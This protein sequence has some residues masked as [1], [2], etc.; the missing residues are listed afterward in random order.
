M[1]NKIRPSVILWNSLVF[2]T[3]IIAAVIN[4]GA[5]GCIVAI[6]SFGAIAVLLEEGL[7]L[8]IKNK[9]FVHYWVILTPLVW[10][11]VLIGGILYAGVWTKEH[12]FDAISDKIDNKFSK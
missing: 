2:L 3:V 8:N 10:I 4:L 9:E 11:L 1:K 5:A 12:I 6:M 7:D